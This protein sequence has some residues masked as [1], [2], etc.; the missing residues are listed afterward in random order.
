M[1]WIPAEINIGEQCYHS[2]WCITVDKLS[3]NNVVLH[4]R[5]AAYSN[6]NSVWMNI[7]YWNGQWSISTCRKGLVHTDGIPRLGFNQYA[8]E[9]STYLRTRLLSPRQD[10]CDVMCTVVGGCNPSR[11]TRTLW[12]EISKYIW[13]WMRALD[14]TSMKCKEW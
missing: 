8:R 10:S 3:F 14:S 12:S 4:C 13:Q 2:T 1:N 5:I 7:W 6:S 11:R 9:Y